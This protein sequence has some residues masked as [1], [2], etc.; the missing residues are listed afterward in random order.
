MLTRRR[1]FDGDR[2]RAVLFNGRSDRLF[3][4][5][6]ARQVKAGDFM[7]AK[8]VR[9][10]TDLGFAHLYLQSRQN[11]WYINPETP[12]LE[13]KLSRVCQRYRTVVGMGF[14][15]GGYALL[16]YSR[17]MGL[18][19]ALVVSPQVSIDPKVV[20]DDTRW[21]HESAEFD[22]AAADLSAHGDPDL[23]GVL[24]ADPFVPADLAHVRAI[25]KVFPG[26][27]IARL[28]GGGH[29]ATNLMRADGHFPLL[30]AELSGDGPDPG[31]IIAAHRASR[32]AVPAYA[33]ALEKARRRRN[34][35]KSEASRRVE[36]LDEG[37][38]SA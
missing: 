20:P 29:P 26:M 32:H 6:R 27:Q 19:R 11:D 9:H 21:H 15:M 10:Y 4:S 5:F 25:Q 12:E 8:H 36:G 34:S 38:R 13:A 31:R 35:R 14:S 22:R 17:A 37:G 30:Q 33:L 3:V 2:M 18:D 16:R 7:T 24:L 28:A 23:R 1:V